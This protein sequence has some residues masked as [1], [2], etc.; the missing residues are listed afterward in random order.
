MLLHTAGSQ[1]G[2][3]AVLRLTELPDPLPAPCQHWRCCTSLWLCSV[4]LPL[5]VL[6]Q[7]VQ[8]PRCAPISHEEFS[9]TQKPLRCLSLPGCK[10]AIPEHC[11]VVPGAVV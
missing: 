2:P 10:A 5:A 6:S 1:R 4:V 8:K 7:E 11:T 3:R 9:H